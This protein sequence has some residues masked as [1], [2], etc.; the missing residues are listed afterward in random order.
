MCGPSAAA[1]P[2][3]DGKQSHPSPTHPRR[4]TAAAIG[5]GRHGGGERAPATHSAARVDARSCRA[6]PGGTSASG[7]TPVK[8]TSQPPRTARFRCSRQARTRVSQAVHVRTRILSQAKLR[9]G[10]H[11][12]AH[13]CDALGDVA[14]GRRLDARLRDPRRLVVV[15]AHELC[16]EPTGLIRP[17]LFV[18]VRGAEALRAARTS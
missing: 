17:G 3:H 15:E 7:R 9:R 6:A 10:A 2:L 16:P 11:S 5:G 18:C 8:V 4:A 12:S 14:E 1:L 13:L